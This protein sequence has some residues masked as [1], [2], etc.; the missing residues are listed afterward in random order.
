MN[1]FPNEFYLHFSGLKKNYKLKFM[2]IENL[3][4]FSNVYKFEA[5]KILKHEFKSKRFCQSYIQDNG[6]SVVTLIKNNDLAD[7]GTIHYENEYRFVSCNI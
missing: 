2:K 5:D 4:H 3:N 1:S 6:Q 7:I